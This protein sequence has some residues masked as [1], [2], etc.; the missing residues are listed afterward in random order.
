[1]ESR[2]QFKRSRGEDFHSSAVSIHTEPSTI[3]DIKVY[4]GSLYMFW[5]GATEIRKWK[6]YSVKKVSDANSLFGIVK[7]QGSESKFDFIDKESLEE[8]KYIR[9]EAVG[10]K[11]LKSSNAV[12]L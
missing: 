4:N 12:K 7:K 10:G 3:P 5:N 8:W 9:A 1:M 6:I 2:N 11:L